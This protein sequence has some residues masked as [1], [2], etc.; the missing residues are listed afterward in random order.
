VSLRRTEPTRRL[1]A[2]GRSTVVI[3]SV[4]VLA[5]FVDGLSDNWVHGA[6]LG[7]AA[8]AVWRDGARPPTQQPALMRGKLPAARAWALL[9][10]A[11][12]YVA[13]TASLPRYSWWVTAAVVAPGV[14]A[15][16]LAWRGPLRDRP[17]PP[18]PGRTGVAVWA[19]VFVAGGLWE[20]AAL[21]LQPSLEVGSYAHPTISYLM[22]SVLAQWTGR[23]LTLALWLALGWLLLAQATVDRRR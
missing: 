15:L 2:R 22:D 3:C 23:C 14:A 20:L 8:A 10:G 21:L 11:G 13:V 19:A 6:V 18:P 17:V 9:G 16:L 7:G 1:S 12:V 4:L 5:G